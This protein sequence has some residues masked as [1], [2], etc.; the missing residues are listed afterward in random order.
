MPA[1]GLERVKRLRAEHT[2]GA[3]ITALSRREK[4]NIHTLRRALRGETYAD[5]AGTY[6]LTVGL[7]GELV[8][9]LRGVAERR[10]SVP[11]EIVKEALLKFLPP[12]PK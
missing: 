9:W 2:L 12:T 10:G 7:P 8:A 5:G 4:I 11:D 3:S 6:W 1:I